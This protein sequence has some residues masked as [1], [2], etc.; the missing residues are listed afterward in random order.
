MDDTADSDAA[1]SG[2]GR[3]IV[4]T[5]TAGDDAL[6]LLMALC[7]DRARV[8]GVTVVAGNVAFEREVENAKYVLELADAADRV[9]VH[10]GARS[11]LLKEFE[12]AEYVHGEGGLGGDLFPETGIPSA[13]GHAVEYLLETVRANPGEVSLLCIGPLTNVALALQYE[14]D[15]NEYVDEVWVMGGA[16]D[17]PGNVTPAAEFNFW[18]D[19]DAAKL[20]LAEL[21]VHLVDWGLTLRDSILD[22]DDFERFGVFDTD[23]AG[24]FAEI[25]GRARE[26]TREEQGVDG[27]T[28]PDSLAAALALAPELREA[29]GE[30][31]ATVDER[32]GVT[33]GHSVV[34]T[35]GV[36]DEAARTR[37]VE[38]ADNDRFTEMVAGLLEA[39][40]PERPLRE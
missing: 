39:G 33:R 36:A 18:V 16:A 26:F 5:D 34:D 22:D 11:P 20:A 21:D 3:V 8:E 23:Y 37:L 28:Q 25:T 32:E 40:D 13:D 1:D 6:A 31:Y 35:G 2:L 15:L 30:Y 12:H 17:A 29:V 4:D 7:S 10:E 9:P 14:P 27:V 38:S 19:P 24:F